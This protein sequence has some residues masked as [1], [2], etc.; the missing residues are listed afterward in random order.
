MKSEAYICQ[1]GI[2]SWVMLVIGQPTLRGLWV[3]RSKQL[4]SVSDTPAKRLTW[5]SWFGCL[6]HNCHRRLYSIVQMKPSQYE[7]SWTT[8]ILCTSKVVQIA[9]IRAYP[10]KI[11]NS[12]WM[13]PRKF[14]W[15]STIRSRRLL[16]Q[17]TRQ[18]HQ[19]LH[20]CFYWQ[21]SLRSRESISGVGTALAS[22]TTSAMCWSLLLTILF[23]E[24]HLTVI[25]SFS[26]NQ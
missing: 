10:L 11:G 8:S 14:H 26:R 12:L 13:T 4:L 3:T 6:P 1:Y 24:N 20:C 22:S 17:L 7:L 5:P 21:Y 2:K 23:S 16:S 15:S 9:A 25:A 18:W 19:H